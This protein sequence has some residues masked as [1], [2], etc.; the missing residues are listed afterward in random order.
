MVVA[1][2]KLQQAMCKLH[3]T[4][5]ILEEYFASLLTHSYKLG[6]YFSSMDY[7]FGQE[8]NC[9]TKLVWL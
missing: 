1:V 9:N 7:I 8:A 6:G 5:T 4:Y 2:E 3:I